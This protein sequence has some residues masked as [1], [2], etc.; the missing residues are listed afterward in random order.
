MVPHFHHFGSPSMLELLAT[1][2]K[3]EAKRSKGFKSGLL[4]RQSHPWMESKLTRQVGQHP[5]GSMHLSSIVLPQ[6]VIQIST[7][8]KLQLGKTFG[9]EEVDDLVMKSPWKCAWWKHC[10]LEHWLILPELC[11][12]KKTKIIWVYMGFVLWNP[13]EFPPISLLTFISA[14]LLMFCV[15]I[16]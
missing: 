6:H 14:L 7:L 9:P 10:D 11:S 15:N 3:S 12:P 8:D 5:Y 1:I 4:A 13:D 16:L 2:S